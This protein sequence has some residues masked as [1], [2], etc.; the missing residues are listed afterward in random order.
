MLLNR[1][2]LENFRSFK[3]RTELDLQNINVF[4]GPNKAGKSNLIMALRFLNALARN[5]WYNLYTDN[6]FDHDDSKR[7]TIEIVFC[8]GNDERKELVKKFFRKIPEN[9][10]ESNPIFEK[11]KYMIVIQNNKIYEER[12]SAINT[13][14][15][16]KDVIIHE[17][18]GSVPNQYVV[19]L[20]S[21][22]DIETIEEFDSIGL[23]KRYGK[24]QNT[25]FIFNVEENVYF[26]VLTY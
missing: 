21:H 16:Y 26:I 8:L 23:Q 15:E 19:D 3:D 7:I 4:V 11:I 1:I 2:S 12:V 17:F 18:D 24:W 10:Y 22:S 5:D 13:I 6:V 9:C 20:N 14:N 25:N